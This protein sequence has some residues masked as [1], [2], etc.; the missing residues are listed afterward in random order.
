LA[1]ANLPTSDPSTTTFPK[2][3]EEPKKSGG[4]PEAG[5][6]WP[7]LYAHVCAN[8]GWTWDYVRNHVDLP[9]LDALNAEWRQH[10]PVHHLV[11]AYL[12]YQPSQH[13]GAPRTPEQE[14]ELQTLMNSMPVATGALALDTSAW[15]AS[16]N[17]EPDH[18]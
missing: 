16:Q 9:T 15:D 5:L 6:N 1:T 8:T 17:K 2:S 12:D 3:R 18:G 10:P 13:A 4:G 14:R 11:A 7:R